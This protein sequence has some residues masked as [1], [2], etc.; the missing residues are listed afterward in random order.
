M[1]RDEYGPRLANSRLV[2][3]DAGDVSSMNGGR[4]PYVPEQGSKSLVRTV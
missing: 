2:T 1:L 3:R 4:E